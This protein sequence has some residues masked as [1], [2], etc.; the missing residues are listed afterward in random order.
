MVREKCVHNFFDVEDVYENVHNLKII[1]KKINNVKSLVENVHNWK[2]IRKKIHNVEI[3]ERLTQKKFRLMAVILMLF[4]G[5]KK[6]SSWVCTFNADSISAPFFI[7]GVSLLR[8]YIKITK[9]GLDL[10]FK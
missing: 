5:S 1:R 3:S 10:A 7:Y 9:N 2:T 6:N 4:I 8:Q